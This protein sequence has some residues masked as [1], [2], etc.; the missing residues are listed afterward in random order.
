[1]GI[2]KLCVTVGISTFSDHGSLLRKCTRSFIQQN[3]GNGNEPFVL[4]DRKQ[5]PVERLDWG[6]FVDLLI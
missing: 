2:E 5:I 4:V 3:R 6:G 1:M